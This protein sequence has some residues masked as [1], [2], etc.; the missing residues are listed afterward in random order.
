MITLIFS[1]LGNLKKWS[2]LPEILKLDGKKILPVNSAGICLMQSISECLWEDYNIQIN[3]D[4]LVSLISTEICNHPDYLKYLRLP[5]SQEEVD[6]KLM[7]FHKSGARVAADM[8][9]P[10]ISSALDLHI[11][12]IQNISGYYGVVNTYPI[13]GFTNK[14]TVTLIIIDGVYHPVVSVS[15]DEELPP[16]Q[17]SSTAV[18]PPQPSTSVDIGNEP[19]PIGPSQVIII[20]SDSESD[21][22]CPPGTSTAVVG[23]YVVVIPETD[24]SS[25]EET[26]GED[27][28]S[29]ITQL[30]N[31]LQQQE[32]NAALPDIPDISLVKQE[33]GTEQDK[34]QSKKVHFT[35]QEFK[36]MVP[37]VVAEIPY[38]INGTKWYMIDVPQED[39]FFTKYRDGRY[40]QLNTS[41]RKG[42]NGIRRVGKCR[43]NFVCENTDCPYL[44]ENGSKNEHQFTT[45]EGKKFCY[46]CHT[47]SFRKECTATKLVEYYHT[48]RVLHV[49]HKGNHTCHLKPRTAENDTFIEENIKKFGAHVGPK[50]LAQL[51]MT[52]EMQKQLNE[53]TTDMDK[54]I[55]ISARLVDKTRIQNIRKRMEREMRSERHSISAV[56]ELKAITDTSDKYLIFRIHDQNMTGTGKSYV[57]KSSRKMVNIMRNMDQTNA[58]TNPLMQEPC[59]FDGMHKRCIGWKTLTLWV[60]HPSSRRL[61]R[62]ATMKTKGETSETTSIFW[63]LLN[64]MIREVANDPLQYFNPYMFITDEAGANHNGILSVYGQSGV[65]KS[66]I[67]QFHFKQSLNR[68]LQKFPPTLNE[69]KAEFEEIM[70]QLLNVPTISQFQE[71]K[72]RAVQISGLVP[73]IKSGLQWWLARRY[74]IFPVF[75]G[76]C[77]SSV[78]MAEI[79][80]STLK[81]V[82]SLALVDAAWDDIC[83]M[84]MQEQEHTKFLEDRSYSFGKG[85]SVADLAEKEKKQQRKRSR[86]YQ[87]AFKENM[88]QTCDDDPVF[89][90]SKR[91]RHREPETSVFDVQGNTL[92]PSHEVPQ[93]GNILQPAGQVLPK[94]RRFEKEQNPPLLAFLHG[95]KITTCFGCKNKFAQSQKNPPDDLILKMQVKRDRLVNQKW[96]QDGKPVG[97]ISI[98]P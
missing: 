3:S 50:K 76:Y 40:F 10:A 66:R 48:E 39:T 88:L 7:S 57:F 74:N 8:Y 45:L 1:G 23:K 21:P 72:T 14:K 63:N 71:L 62:L 81:R 9:I 73:A 26:K 51:K 15:S 95:F 78:N 24:P 12:T 68:M 43:G 2:D 44:I 86:T 87:Q 67:C 96:V 25:Q 38:D 29:S 5:V 69:I 65:M 79:G 30:Q 13:S 83:S 52:E 47:L 49:Y 35:L 27:L 32:E 59:Y 91:A 16:A 90:P 64:E 98:Y 20:S 75:R 37:D 33:L 22:D 17:P 54:I 36:D 92:Q 93:T 11:R 6:Y 55:D 56:A 58:K 97:D 89:I 34:Y 77:L 70:L 46:S 94:P 53:G 18:Q 80:H 19:Q 84:I 4:K 82:K 42:F 41:R 28:L 61:L 60:F 31:N 85:P